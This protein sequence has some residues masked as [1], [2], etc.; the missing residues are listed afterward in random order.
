MQCGRLSWLSGAV[1]RV[2]FPESLKNEDVESLI[3]GM[4]LG[5]GWRPNWSFDEKGFWV[6]V[7]DRDAE[8]WRV[9]IGSYFPGSN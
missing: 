1:A 5:L 2:Y 3:V 8:E 7:P 9:T 4:T 6:E